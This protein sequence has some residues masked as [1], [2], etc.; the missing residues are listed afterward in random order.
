MYEILLSR[1]H[2]FS[3]LAC[4]LVG[5]LILSKT[6]IWTSISTEW[7][8]VG[9]DRMAPA[10]IVVLINPLLVGVFAYLFDFALGLDNGTATY[11]GQKS[12]TYLLF[13][14]TACVIMVC[15]FMIFIRT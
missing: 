11:E 5:V 4:L 12:L 13:S 3:Q 8:F 7:V 1:V 6:G 15:Q 14:L 9:S 2:I 10:L